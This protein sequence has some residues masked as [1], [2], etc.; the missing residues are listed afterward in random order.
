M[1]TNEFV[2][3]DR[4]DVLEANKEIERKLHQSVS[5]E[6]EL[7]DSEDAL[8]VKDFAGKAAQGEIEAVAGFNPS[9]AIDEVIEVQTVAIAQDLESLPDAATLV[10]LKPETV[11]GADD[12]AQ[13][14]PANDTP[15]RWICKLIITFPNGS[16]FVGT[17]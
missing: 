17:E 9:H 6:G 3:S 1:T 16:R 7:L 12:R 2:A 11:C 8:I 14:T 4:L 15:W 10:Y 13:I 5:S